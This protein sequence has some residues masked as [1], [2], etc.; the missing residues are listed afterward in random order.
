MASKARKPVALSPSAV[1]AKRSTGY[2]RAGFEK[3]LPNF[4]RIQTDLHA[5]VVFRIV[6]NGLEIDDFRF[7]IEQAH[8]KI[9][10]LCSPSTP[11]QF[12]PKADA[13]EGWMV[14]CRMNGRELKRPS[15]SIF[16][17]I[18]RTA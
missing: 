8:F 5:A 18:L 11:F 9:F 14:L 16:S 13:N 12:Y 6:M 10:T 3:L 2:A 7:A 4:Q 1:R 17:P 15:L